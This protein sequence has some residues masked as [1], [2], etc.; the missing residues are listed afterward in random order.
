MSPG[1]SFRSGA[2]RTP[3][4]K[5]FVHSP[6]LL[7]PDCGNQTFGVLMV[8][9]R[10]YVRRCVTCWFDASFPLPPLHKRIIYLDQF[11]ISNMMKELDPE[12]GRARGYYHALFCA[13]DRLSSLQLIVCPDSPIHDH[14]SLVDPRY[15]KIRAVFRQLSHGVGLRD[16]TT[17]LH[18]AITRAFDN[19]LR[20][21]ECGAGVSADFAFTNK[22][23]VWQDWYRIDLNY[24][25]P[26]L[27]NELII[28][29]EIVTQ[30]LHRTCEEWRNDRHFSFRETFENELAGCG[31]L[32]L[33]RAGRYIM[34]YGAVATGQAPFD[35]EVS[36]PPPEAMLVTRMLRALEQTFATPDE[37]LAR[38]RE[39]F[40]SK[41]FQ[42]LSVVRI[43][44]LF[45]ATI[46]REINA[47][48]KPD[49]FPTASMFND[50]DA[51]AQYSPFCDAMFVDKEVSHFVKQRELREELGTRTRFFSLR[52]GEKED[53][54]E[55][56]KSIEEEADADHL[57]LVKDVYGSD[58]PTPFV[59]L[60]ASSEK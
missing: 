4:V 14:E 40:A 10:H 32:I 44:S 26:G 50:I 27:A 20:D 43:P 22:P 9:D 33:Q 60:L 45:W 58:W 1:R 57:R 13:V 8:C 12:D 48:R 2:K 28:N 56:L 24:T 17:L 18:A 35:D 46:G 37:R 23:D 15:Q 6:F 25:V 11:V 38:I 54:L 36:F 47:G 3:K 21:E 31:R 52:K 29:R 51:V 55:Y 30:E 53:F 39:F 59:D 42:S 7:C 41:Q 16:P 5:Q 19:W 34:H 49:R